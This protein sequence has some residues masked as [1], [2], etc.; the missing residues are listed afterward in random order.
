MLVSLTQAEALRPV[1]LRPT[2]NALDEDLKLR[3]SL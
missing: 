2:I 3:I 1:L